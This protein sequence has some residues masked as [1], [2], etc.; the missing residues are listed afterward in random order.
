MN[1]TIPWQDIQTQPMPDYSVLP[2]PAQNNP[3]VFQPLY[4][5]W[6]KSIYRYIYFRVGNVKDAED[7]TRLYNLP[8]SHR[9]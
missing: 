5:K 2:I 9:P 4:Q 6:L 7:L 1:Q 8:A 3:A